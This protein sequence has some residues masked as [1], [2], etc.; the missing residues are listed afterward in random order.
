MS[1]SLVILV[2]DHIGL[3]RQGWYERQCCGSICNLS[4][5]VTD[6][7]LKVRYY[8]TGRLHI[9]RKAAVFERVVI[10]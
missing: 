10:L 7:P 2:R 3:A 5:V 1:V 8:H 6:N 9:L 4:L